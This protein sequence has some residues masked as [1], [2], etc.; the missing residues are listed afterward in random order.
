MARTR[1]VVILSLAATL[2]VVTAILFA[3]R[4]SSS[5]WGSLARLFRDDD[6]H[7]HWELLAQ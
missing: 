6:D 5:G 1:S 7:P 2:A 3:V 4:V